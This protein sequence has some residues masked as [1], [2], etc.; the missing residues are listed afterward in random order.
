MK[1]YL[2]L[3]RSIDAIQNRFFYVKRLFYLVCCCFHAPCIPNVISN[4]T[5]CLS[6]SPFFSYLSPLHPAPFDLPS[7]SFLSVSPVPV[8]ICHASFDLSFFIP[9]LSNPCPPPFP[10]FLY[11][12]H[13]SLCLLFVPRNSNFPWIFPF[14]SLS[15]TSCSPHRPM[16]FRPFFWRYFQIRPQIIKRQCSLSKEHDSFR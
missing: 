13:F 10:H 11:F 5:I 12:F 4:P 6:F 7:I 16:I 2:R 9:C 8:L 15:C 1:A 14:R 3:R